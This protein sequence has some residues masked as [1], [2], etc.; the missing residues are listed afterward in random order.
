MT[1]VFALGNVLMGDDGV[2]PAVVRGFEAA[3]AVPPDVDVVDLG[4]PGLD[5]LPWLG[6][7]D[8]VILV[9]AVKS[10][11]PPGT[12][13]VYD[14]NDIMRHA[15]MPRIGPHDPGVKAA[16]FALEFA[17][18]APRE[19]V[20]V[21][22]VPATTAIGLEL[23]PAVLAAVPAAIEQVAAALRRF[24]VAIDRRTSMEVSLSWPPIPAALSSRSGSA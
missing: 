23:S 2:G 16:L 11:R 20:L 9:D 5:L 4:T 7:V 22:I 12:V 13:L 24:G 18:R 3:Y 21:G 15:P 6:D 17:G 14:K 10:D 8:R 19:V 1:S